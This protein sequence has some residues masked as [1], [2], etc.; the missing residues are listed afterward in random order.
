MKRILSVSLLIA[1]LAFAL[2]A[3]AH[4]QWGGGYDLTWNT[5]DGGG[6][7][8]GSGS[9]YALVGTIGQPDASGTMTGSGFTLTGGFWT[10]EDSQHC[11]YLPIA[12]RS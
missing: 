3:T 11:I 6:G 8:A 7:E 2:I 1:V 12:I 4:A 5:I 10:G 9:G